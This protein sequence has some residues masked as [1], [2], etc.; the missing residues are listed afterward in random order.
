LAFRGGLGHH[1]RVTDPDGAQAPGE[2][3][4]RR[5]FLLQLSDALRPLGDSGAIQREASR[6]LRAHL[7]AS[8]VVY[9]DA[10]DCGTL[11]VVAY[12]VLPGISDLM[13]R[14]YRLS[15]YGPGIEAE[16]A[17]GDTLWRDDVQ[18]DAR[19]SDAEKTEYG[20][21][22]IAAFATAPIVKDGRLVGIVSAHCA[23]P[24]R[25]S[26]AELGLIEETAERT[27][28]AVARARAEEALR[29]A[30][31]ELEARVRERTTQLAEANRSLAA[32]VAERRA[33]EAQ[34]KAL[35]E[36]LVSAQE[37]ERRRIARNIH[38][39]LGQQITA[40]RMNLERLKMQSGEASTLAQAERT[41][42]LAEELDR[43]IDFLTWE[44]RPATLDHLG[45]G[46]ALRDLVDGWAD[47]FHI[48]AEYSLVGT[49]TRLPAHVGANLY[50]LVQEALHNVFKHARATRAL[51]SLE[52]TDAE[53]MLTVS[54]NGQGFDM[55]SVG[56]R[57]PDCLGLVSMR[58]RATLVGGE[59]TVQTAPGQGTTIRVRV[60]VRM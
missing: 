39:Q 4:A 19:F 41:L 27:W 28:A 13:G 30:H 45:L 20:N 37:E 51:V 31:D 21:L 18:A 16:L 17:D 47:R 12:D 32:E 38:D 33:A 54:D 1:L 49:T 43:S 42:Y 3:E 56:P 52:V 2:S 60:P 22:Q 40:L 50:R 29:R 55:Q 10:L 57:R 58:E 35:F 25:W 46:S 14:R 44:L 5:A 53:L 59:L 9:T 24:H 15:D 48:A 11:E 6:V 26:R 36:R 8:R 23:W 34:I 7:G